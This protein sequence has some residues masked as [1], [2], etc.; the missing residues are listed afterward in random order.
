MG[1]EFKINI[2]Y[3]LPCAGGFGCPCGKHKSPTD[4]EK[5]QLLQTELEKLTGTKWIRHPGRETFLQKFKGRKG[6]HEKDKKKP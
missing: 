3:T 5:A 4:A 6:Y 1:Q 2:S